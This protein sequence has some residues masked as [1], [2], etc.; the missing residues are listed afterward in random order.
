MLALPSPGCEAFG[1]MPNLS[2]SQ[3]PLIPTEADSKTRIQYQNVVGGDPRKFWE[4]NGEVRQGK[5]GT[6]S[7]VHYQASNHTG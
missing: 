4:A 2:G 5:E 3:L 6:P 7:R 1:K